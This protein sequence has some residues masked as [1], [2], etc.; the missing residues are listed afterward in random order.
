MEVNNINNNYSIAID[1][2][3]GAGKSTM[4]KRI[5]QH[6]GLI[7][8]DTGAI[9]RTVALYAIEKGITDQGGVSRLLDEIDIKLIHDKDGRQR[10]LLAGRDVSEE[11]RLPEVSLCAS[12]VSAMPPVRAFLLDMQRKFAEEHNVVMDG[13]DIGTVVLPNASIKIFL[14][15]SCEDRA[16]RRYKELEEKGIDTTYEKVYND[17]VYRDKNDSNRET[18]P[19]KPAVDA[20][21]VDTTGFT[22]EE[23]TGLL[24]MLIEGKKFDEG[25]V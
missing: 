14:T 1:G 4:A 21:I 22:L 16:R 23:T 8:I 17:I 7:Y 9:Y 20:I 5:A 18:S 10:M 12:K 19:L 11:I 2:P 25:C 6:F 24:I 3:S 13:R 15:A